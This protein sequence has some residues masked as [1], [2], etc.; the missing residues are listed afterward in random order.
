MTIRRCR[1]FMSGAFSLHWH[2]RRRVPSRRIIDSNAA[3]TITRCRLTLAAENLSEP[4]PLV[5][6]YSVGSLNSGFKMMLGT[7]LVRN[8]Q[9][10]HSG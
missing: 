8:T 4:R 6:E 2:L 5:S 1:L 9:A 7:V 10:N 3:T